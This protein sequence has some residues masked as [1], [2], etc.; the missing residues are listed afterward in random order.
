MRLTL[1]STLG[2]S[3]LL[4]QA[5]SDESA[6]EWQAP[7]SNDCESIQRASDNCR[8]PTNCL[9]V[10]GPCPMLNTLANH[11]FLPRDGRQ[12]TQ[13]VI[14]SGLG[15]GLNFDGSLAKLMF[16]MAVPANPEP[17]ATFFTLYVRANPG[18]IA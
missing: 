8:R 16:E 5:D 11:G 13:D 2:L 17:N 1:A 6:G 14:V 4:V 10:R 3:A 7:G 15:K 9:I 18:T 12:L